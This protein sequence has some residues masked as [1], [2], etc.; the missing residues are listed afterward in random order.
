MTHTETWECAFDRILG[1]NK[2]FF[3]AYFSSKKTKTKNDKVAAQSIFTALCSLD[4][5]KSNSFF[6]TL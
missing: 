5:D 6:P 4:M 3:E 2:S 1:N